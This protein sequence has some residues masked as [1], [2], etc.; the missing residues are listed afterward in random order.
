[1]DVFMV[2]INLHCLHNPMVEKK[3]RSHHIMAPPGAT[4]IVAEVIPLG[5]SVQC[6]RKTA[7]VV[8]GG[9]DWL[10]KNA[11]LVEVEAIE[12]KSFSGRFGPSEK[13]SEKMM[14]LWDFRG[15]TL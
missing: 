7:R 2:D 10:L 15:F 11:G 13:P 4:K 9:T 3:Q 8:E 6:W 14:V 1:M 5:R 12:Q